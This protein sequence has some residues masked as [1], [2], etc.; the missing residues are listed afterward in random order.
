MRTKQHY[1]AL[2][3]RWIAAAVPH[4]SVDCTRLHAG[5]TAAQYP[6]DVAG[7][8]GFIRLLWG[9]L[10]LIS[11]GVTPPWHDKFITGVRHGC[12]PQHPGYWGDVG[13]NDQRAQQF[14][15]DYRYYFTAD[16]AGIHWL[17]CYVSADP[18]A[19]RPVPDL[20]FNDATQ[21]LT[22]NSKTLTIV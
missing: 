5:D 1:S 19:V 3:A 13:D 20:T 21:H 14:A 2:I 11:G 17:A 22:V 12:D 7:M 9:L 8:E 10:P 16:G 18:G 15:E 4:L 6:D